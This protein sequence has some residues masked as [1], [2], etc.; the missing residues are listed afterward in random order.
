[1]TLPP[2]QEAI[3]A[4]SV[5][6]TGTFVE[7]PKDDV[8]TSIP[9]R[10][11]KI[12]TLYPDRLAVKMGQRA[13]TYSELNQRANRLAHEILEKQ[14]PISEPVALFFEHEIDVVV[15]ILGVLKAG[16]FY[17][18]LDSSFPIERN[19]FLLAN[20]GARMILMNNRSAELCNQLSQ[21][22]HARINLDTID[23]TKPA[24]DISVTI[25]PEQYA[26]LLY[27]SGST[28]E[29]KG[30]AH[31]HGSYLYRALANAVEMQVTCDD[32]LSLVHGISSGSSRLHLFLSLLH[33]SLLSLFDLKQQG[34]HLLTKWLR[35]E[36]I[37]LCNLPPVV[38]RYL[39]DSNLDK[40]PLPYLRMISLSGGPVTLDEFEFYKRH[41]ARNTFLRI[42]LGTTE[43]VEVCSCILSSDFQY[44]KMGS[45]IGYPVAGKEIL[46]IDDNR[47]EVGE[48]EIGEIA[49]KSRHL[50]RGYWRFPELT[51]AK[52]VVGSTLGAEKIYLTGDLGKRLPDGFLIHMGRK[53]LMVNIRGYSVY[54][55]EIERAIMKHPDVKD[56]GV[57]VWER[58]DGDNFL[59]AYIVSRSETQPA[60]DHIKNFLGQ[61][62]PH[63]AIPSA[64]VFLDKLPLTNG[65]LDRRALPRPDDRRP[66][67]NTSY[68][69]ARNE[70]DA[71]LVRIW[72][73]VLDVNPVGI[74]DNFFDLGGDSL[75][76]TR[77]VSRVIKQFQLEIPLQS[78]FQSPTIADMAAVITAHQGKALDEQGLATMLD[79][80]ESLSEE[81]AEQLLGKR[82]HDISK[83]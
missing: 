49:V 38:L 29:P 70:T 34:A 59:A 57:R 50:P 6:P 61:T 45:P 51:S 46:L 53:D 2:E 16:K 82:H 35:E 20:S 14:G 47:E 62:L 30:V 56:T 24:N 80:L 65:K 69:Q 54:L 40:R 76:A 12:V 71:H 15:A 3:K 68:A 64:F 37:T 66:K 31:P 41:F 22:G 11:E 4:K 17:V 43:T 44:P 18:A 21:N 10:F 52:F 1:M 23:E 74:H 72:E 81:D 33:G 58:Y 13:L 27:T 78:L 36:S 9:A 7:L 79:E 60:T 32:K 67:L 26:H 83:E 5:H 19:R 25:S 48:G 8:K 73:E 77:V 55:E 42:Y 28:G 39:A 75:A 63:Y